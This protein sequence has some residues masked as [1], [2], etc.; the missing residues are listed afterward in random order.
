MLSG[1]YL[2][3]YQG[4]RTMDSYIFNLYYDFSN[5]LRNFMFLSTVECFVEYNNIVHKEN[6][7]VIDRIRKV[8]SNQ[9][10][11]PLELSCLFSNSFDC[12]HYQMTS[13]ELREYNHSQI[14]E[15]KKLKARL[16]EME[17]REYT[18]EEAIEVWAE[19]HSAHFRKQWH[20]KKLVQVI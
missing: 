9:M 4:E 14:V 2:Q 6:Q 11:K 18:V 12:K 20:F 5:Y 3:K 17:G 15:I 7:A 8:M 16:E 1:T 19:K 13:E 10:K